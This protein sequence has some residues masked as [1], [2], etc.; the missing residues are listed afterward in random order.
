MSETG[1]LFSAQAIPKP[2]LKP[3]GQ[4]CVPLIPASFIAAFTASQ[5]VLR[6]NCQRI[7]SLSLGGIFIKFL[8]IS[9]GVGTAR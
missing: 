7:E 3:F 9:E 6:E 1:T 2:C 5:A 8:M 4:A